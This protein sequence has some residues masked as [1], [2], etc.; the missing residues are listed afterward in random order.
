M[1]KD[2]PS[3]SSYSYNTGL[4]TG[5]LASQEEPQGTCQEGG[6]IGATGEAYQHSKG[7]VANSLATEKE[8]GN[9]RK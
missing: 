9:N 4:L 8:D 5:L 7:E 1:L 6:G 3:L 2:W